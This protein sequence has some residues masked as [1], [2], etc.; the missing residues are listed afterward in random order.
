MSKKTA[1]I[2]KT[3]WAINP[4]EP[5]ARGVLHI[6]PNKEF[7]MKKRVLMS[8]VLLAIIGTS[9]VF[10][11]TP[12]LD[13]LKFR[14]N[15][16]SYLVDPANNQISGEVVIPDTYNNKPVKTVGVFKDITGITSVTIPAS[17]DS[18][19]NNAFARCTNLT[20]VTFLSGRIKQASNTDYNFP[21]DLVDKF[22]AGGP[23]T[24][25]R[26]AGGKNW[27]KQGGSFSLSGTWTRSTDGMKITIADNGQN[28]TITG[29]KPDNG[30]KLND[31]YTKK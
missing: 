22:N 26:P 4:A 3:H 11:Q 9:A 16:S 28:I 17:V 7:F 15:V 18:I 21:G 5:K 6:N 14:E 12:T 31:T 8:L 13:K 29:D 1:I 30:G 23:G 19:I 24:Y 2:T 10:A 25:T 27:T 20:S